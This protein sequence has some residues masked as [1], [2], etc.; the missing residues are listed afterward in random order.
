M[1]G[2]TVEGSD[3]ALLTDSL[4][5]TMAEHTGPALDVALDD[6]GWLERTVIGIGME[7]SCP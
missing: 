5:A 6:L 3:I 7:R 1:D 2:R 4:R